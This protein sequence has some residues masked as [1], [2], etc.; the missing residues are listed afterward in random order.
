MGVTAIQLRRHPESQEVF[1]YLV[2]CE[3]KDGQPEMATSI[4]TKVTIALMS[5]G[6]PVYEVIQ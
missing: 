6:T 3:W 1:W 4:S 2:F 5:G